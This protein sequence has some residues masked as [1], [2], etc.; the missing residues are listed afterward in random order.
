MKK[1]R[2]RGVISSSTSLEALNY[3]RKRPGCPGRA[4]T[5]EQESRKAR[6]NGRVEKAK[7]TSV[8]P[9]GKFSE[10]LDDKGNGQVEQQ[11]L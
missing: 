7:K 2:R 6:K 4:P 1:E 10:S 5:R 11:N 9:S 8:P 3:E